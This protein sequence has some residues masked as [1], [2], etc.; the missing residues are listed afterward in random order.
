[1]RAL[2]GPAMLLVVVVGA[3]AYRSMSKE[4]KPSREFTGLELSIPGQQGSCYSLETTLIANALFDKATR[5]WKKIDDRAWQLTAESVI[6]GYNGPT[7]QF[8]TLTFEKRGNAVELV[9]VEASPE[10]PQDPL[11]ALDELLTVPNSMHS[12]PVARCLEPG[13][14]GY[15][16]KRK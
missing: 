5:T 4:D 9:K 1:M 14:S 15:L 7:R 13:T 6:Q 16:F 8:S 2:A 3:T 11:A 12:T 10:L